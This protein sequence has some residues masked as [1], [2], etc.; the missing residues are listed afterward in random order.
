MLITSNKKD[1]SHNIDI[2]RKTLIIY[3]EIPLYFPRPRLENSFFVN[4]YSPSCIAEA[5]G[6]VL[7]ACLLSSI[8]NQFSHIRIRA[9]TLRR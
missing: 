1:K 5:S 3:I 6:S 9:F 8:A 4:W 2:N 7:A